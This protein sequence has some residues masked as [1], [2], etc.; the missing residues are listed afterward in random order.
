MKLPWPFKR[1]D[2]EPETEPL[3]EDQPLWVLVD[4]L[5]A[6]QV[7]RDQRAYIRVC[8]E[9]WELRRE[10]KQVRLDELHRL[11]AANLGMVHKPLPKPRPVRPLSAPTRRKR[12]QEKWAR[13]KRNQRQRLKL[14]HPA[15]DGNAA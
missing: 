13:Q 11:A 12:Q 4:N 6:G 10:L 2:P 3:P 1:Q 14:V 7:P 5:L 9:N 8:V 15:K